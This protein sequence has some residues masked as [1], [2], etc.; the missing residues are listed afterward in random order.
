MLSKF[1]DAFWGWADY[2]PKDWSNP[3]TNGGT[4]PS[5]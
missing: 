5:R 3:H 4:P 1:F 2:R